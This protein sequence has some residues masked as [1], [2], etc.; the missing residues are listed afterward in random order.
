M[1]EQAESVPQCETGNDY[2]G[3]LGVRISAIFVILFGSLLAAW[4]PVYAR[5]HKG[6]HIPEVAYFIAKYFGSGVIIATAFIH[7]LAPA[8][9]ALGNECLTGPITDYPWAVGIPLMVV[10]VMFIVELLA[11]RFEI[12]G[13]GETFDDDDG[14]HFPPDDEVG[15]AESNEGGHYSHRSDHVDNEQ[16]GENHTPRANGGPAYEIQSVKPEAYSAQLTSVFI[17]EFGVIFHSIFIGLTLAV[18]GEGFNILYVVLVFHQT[19]EGLGL[20]TR[21]AA[22]SWPRSRRWTPYLLGIAYGL[23]TPIAIS[24]GLGV[25]ESFSPEGRTTL[26]INGVFDAISAGILLYTGLIEL[27]AHEF[28]F[29]HEMR[30]A[31]LTRLMSAFGIMALGAAVVHLILTM[32]QPTAIAAVIA[33]L[34]ARSKAQT[35]DYA[36]PYSQSE[37]NGCKDPDGTNNLKSC[38][39]SFDC[40]SEEESNTYQAIAQN[41]ADAPYSISAASETTRSAAPGSRG[42]TPPDNGEN[43]ESVGSAYASDP[44]IRGEPF[45]RNGEGFGPG[46]RGRGDS[47]SSWISENPSAYASWTS[48]PSVTAPPFATA[49]EESDF[50]GGRGGPFGHM[51]RGPFP[52]SGNWMD[53]PW[54]NWWRS[55]GVCPPSSWEG[56]TSGPWGTSPPWT[57]WAGCTASTTATSSATV[58]D[59]AGSTTVTPTYGVAV[60][61]VTATD[62][63]TTETGSADAAGP[64]D[65]SGAAGGA[66]V[67]ALGAAI[68]VA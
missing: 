39:S 40:S 51:S 55:S 56:W 59:S 2:D 21:L 38:A 62:A 37:R 1:A 4:F 58:T 49:T 43:W 68:A 35:Q 67:V 63:A 66:L 13:K 23:T 54:T 6:T 28:M 48:A 41:C 16:V 15:K 42:F 18:Q 19:F 25:R 34:V 47:W 53:G 5:R 44:G 24:I 27:M 22:V 52:E 32:K 8:I 9:E 57:S 10:F 26:I 46:G 33:G 61:A 65:R 50:P 36:G 64:T 3:N 20:G 7:L 31:S 14:H 60:N 29:S 30:Q 11:M 12:F 45:G 17:L